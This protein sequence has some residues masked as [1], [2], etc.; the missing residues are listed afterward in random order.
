M[1]HSKPM[2]AF[3]PGRTGIP[4]TGQLR[5]SAPVGTGVKRGKRNHKDEAE[6]LTEQEPCD[7]KPQHSVSLAPPPVEKPD[8]TVFTHEESDPGIAIEWREGKKIE[9][10]EKEIQH[11]KYAEKS[12]C[13]TSH[14]G[15]RRLGN[16][17]K[18][19][20]TRDAEKS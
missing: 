14:S 13:E 8:G 11:E 10:A 15:N 20:R 5:I 18:T 6:H 9:R 3:E 17:S 1:C 16:M 12:G 19:R 4:R 7:E 2:Y